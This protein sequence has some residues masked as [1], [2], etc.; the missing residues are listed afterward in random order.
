MLIKEPPEWPMIPQTQHIKIEIHHFHP[1]APSCG[2]HLVNVMDI[3]F[4]IQ[5]RK[6]N[7][8]FKVLLT[9]P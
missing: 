6:L 5:I 1:E 9:S 3:S 2:S 8:L 7:V 4:I